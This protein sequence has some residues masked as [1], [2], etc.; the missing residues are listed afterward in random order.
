MAVTVYAKKKALAQAG[1]QILKGADALHR[2]SDKKDDFHRELLL[3]RQHYRLR[4][5]GDKILGDVSF[6]TCGSRNLLKI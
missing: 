3:L 2:P 4:R 1:S 6:R 5:S